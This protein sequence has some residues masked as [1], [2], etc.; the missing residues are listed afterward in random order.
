MA[1]RKKKIALKPGF[2]LM[3]WNRLCSKATKLNGLNGV[4]KPKD[5]WTK[6][7]V[8]KHKSKYDGWMIIRGEVYNVTP[9]LPYHPGGDQIMLQLLGK[10][11]TK[12]FDKNHDYVSLH[13]LEACHVGTLKV[14]GK[15]VDNDDDDVVVQNTS[16][17]THTRRFDVA[18][19]LI[20]IARAAVVVLAGFGVGGSRCR[21]PRR[22]RRVASWWR[23]GAGKVAKH[24]RLGEWLARSHLHRTPGCCLPGARS[25]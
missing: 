11:A 8:K 4:P 24:C 14:H 5:G 13:M 15:P 12:D 9:Y 3:D 7:E 23:R 16:R 10:D 22:G 19:D 21:L 20:V 2:S 25:R 6:A 18:F 17:V 1:L